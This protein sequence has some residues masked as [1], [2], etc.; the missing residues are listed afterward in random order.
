MNRHPLLPGDDDDPQQSESLNDSAAET[1][2][3]A[4][5]ASGSPL[6]A[7]FELLYREQFGAVVSYFARRYDDPQLVADLTADTFVA[8][9]QSFRERD[10]DALSPRAWAIG[11]A[12]KVWIRYRESDPRAED[13]ARRGSIERLLDPAETEELTLWIDIERASRELFERL[14]RMPRLDREAVELVDLCALSPAEAAR[15]LGVS[16]AGLRVRLARSRA[17]LGR[18]GGERG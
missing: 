11:I 12:R 3:S 6:L 2:G 7:E 16:Q 8:A 15:Q 14:R 1:L 13:R 17:R 4:S 5:V 9:I 10:V 18:E